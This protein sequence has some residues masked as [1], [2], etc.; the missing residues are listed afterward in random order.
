MTDKLQTILGDAA[1]AGLV[2]KDKVAPLHAYLEAHNV[3]HSGVV[4][5]EGVLDPN[6]ESEMPRFIRGY[7]DILITIGVVVTLVAIGGLWT[8]FAVVPA[9]VVLAE[10]F[11]K[12]QRLALPSFVL[13]VA[14]L[15]AG[16]LSTLALLD[17]FNIITTDSLTDMTSNLD[18]SIAAGAVFLLM[19]LFYWR[20]RVPVAFAGLLIAGILTLMGGISLLLPF[21]DAIMQPV[22]LF[23]GGGLL[24]VLAIYYDLL[25][26]HRLTRR[27]DV[28]FWLY[29][30]GVPAI[31]KAIFDVL[32]PASS[33]ANAVVM[34]VAVFFMMLLGL[35][36]DRRAFVT[37]GLI[38]LGY[39]F[40]TLLEKGT[41]GWF[42]NLTGSSQFLWLLLV[43]GL[44]VLGFGI[45]W[46]LWR[47]L[48]L[49]ALPSAMLE[50]L[51]D[52]R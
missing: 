20:Y 7:H 43:V 11:V 26:P 28:A 13:T 17:Q 23:G 12:R 45:A 33:S 3:V 42:A 50:R 52:I 19:C 18:S 51:P 21:E 39:A 48:L 35:I 44:V 38:Y 10:I 8:V 32:D 36:L 1:A 41:A 2:E 46:R 29:L 5:D 30:V 22:L 9:I 40:S 6:E 47:R 16:S 31:L 14:T 34:V 4:E 24:V 27:S 49:G 25:D 37:A 15:L